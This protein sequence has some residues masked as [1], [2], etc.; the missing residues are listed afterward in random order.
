MMQ[1][2][3]VKGP[4]RLAELVEELLSYVFQALKK[5]MVVFG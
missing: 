4:L 1:A 2:K 3:V 5:E